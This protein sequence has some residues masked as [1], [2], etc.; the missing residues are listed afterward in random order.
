MSPYKVPKIIEF[1]AEM[2]LTTVGKID[3]KALR[4]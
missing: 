4:S 1:I 2:P 3:K